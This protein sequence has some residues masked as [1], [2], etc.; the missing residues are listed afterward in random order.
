MGRRTLKPIVVIGFGEALSA[1]EVAWSLADQG[2][3]V[4]AFTRRGRRAPLKHSRYVRIFEVTP[5]ETDLA[6]TVK[7]L[8]D[9]V[10]SLS[11]ASHVPVTIMPLD[12]KA[13]WLCGRT[14]V[15]RKALLVGP[16]GEALDLALDKRIQMEFA[17]AAGFRVPPY[18]SVDRPDEISN[19]E[20]NFPVV[21][22][23]ALATAK[24]AGT[25]SRGQVWICADW[26]ELKAAVSHWSGR[27]PMVLQQFIPGVGEGIF[28]LATARGVM[29]WSGH[30]RVRMMN[31][32]GSGSSACTAVSPVDE[33]SRVSAQRLLDAI[34]WRGLFMV[35]LLRDTA[36]NLWFI[37]FNGRAWGSMALARRLGFEYPAW[38]VQLALGSDTALEIP[39]A[40]DGVPVCRHLA[41]EIL[42]LLFV[43]QGSKSKALVRWP[44][45][46][47]ALFQVCRIG[48]NDCW[49]NWRSDDRK[50]FFSDSFGSVWSKIVG[51]KTEQ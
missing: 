45:I 22:K 30:R 37:E 12:D 34:G 39:S 16:E 11:S 43:L 3:E 20:V 50:V 1:P 27:G 32:Q 33:Q 6:E 21:F 19:E 38:A 14:D 44:S 40:K 48:R 4:M 36:G 51:Q 28:G 18:R 8:A 5:P 49:Y 7:D 31:P 25:L 10:S 13:L 15:R 2:F 29:A 42:Y 24:T 26:A 35:E 17:R 46:W 9:A 47:T 23:P 41:R